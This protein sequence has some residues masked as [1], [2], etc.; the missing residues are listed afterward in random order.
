MT[1]S[2]KKL[3]SATVDTN[4]FVSGLIIKHG[5]PYSLL[6]HWRRG[7]FLLVI[8][9]DQRIELGD[10][11]RRDKITREYHIGQDDIKSILR[12]IDRTAVFVKALKAS[13]VT[14]RDPKDEKILATAIAGKADYLVTGDKDLLVL[15]G[16]PNLATLRIVTVRDFLSLLSTYQKTTASSRG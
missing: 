15:N 16:E 6:Q 11:L 14:V 8:S 2:R 9:K 10:V 1:R 5:N 7:L 4:L 13:P 3:I 12:R